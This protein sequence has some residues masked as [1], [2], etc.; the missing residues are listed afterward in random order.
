MTADK[1]I[2]DM[3]GGELEEYAYAKLGQLEDLYVTGFMLDAEAI[4]R[5]WKALGHPVAA[6]GWGEA[7]VQLE[8][9]ADAIEQAIR[10]VSDE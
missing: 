1:P 9:A 8:K 10:E 6:A 7:A 5:R 3:D 4:S 2:G